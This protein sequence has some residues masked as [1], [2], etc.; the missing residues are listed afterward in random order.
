MLSAGAGTIG[1]G[2]AMLYLWGL[3]TLMARRRRPSSIQPQTFGKMRVDLMIRW[4]PYV[5]CLAAMLMALGA[6]LLTVG[7]ATKAS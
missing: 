4:A 2:L 3:G 6:I 1:F 5:G 7:V